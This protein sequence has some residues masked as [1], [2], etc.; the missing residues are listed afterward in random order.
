MRRQARNQCRVFLHQHQELVEPLVAVITLELIQQLAG[1]AIQYT[2]NVGFWIG[3]QAKLEAVVDQPPSLAVFTTNFATDQHW[4]DLHPLMLSAGI[5][6][7]PIRDSP[8]P[9]RERTAHSSAFPT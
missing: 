4:Y 6:P 3:H 5:E 1:M 2:G 7:R 9:L 8:R